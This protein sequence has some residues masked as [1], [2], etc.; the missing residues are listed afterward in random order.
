MNIKEYNLSNNTENDF[1]W[2]FVTVEKFLS[3]IL[4]SKL[5]F[6]R[7][8]CFEDVQEG[9]SLELLLLNHLKDN[10]MTLAPFNQLSQVHSID[11]FPKET[12]GLIDKLKENQKYNFANCWYLSKNN[13]ESVAMWNLYSQPN[14]MALNIKYS[15]FYD[16][17][18]KSKFDSRVNLKTLTFG[19]IKY[20]NFQDPYELNRIKKEIENTAFIKDQSFIHE[21]EFRIVAEIE[22]YENK[23]FSPKKGFSKYKQKEF[24]D[25]N[26]QIY[27]L[28]IS[29]N[30]FLD[31]EFEIVFHPKITSWI[32]KDLIKILN[33]FKIPYKTRDSKLKLN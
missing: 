4:N 14:G 2:K 32:K 15:K 7:I 25:R 17:I 12:D 30:G 6:T 31:Y 24:Y 9:I 8:D 33:K 10:L 27:G 11:M 13:I 18:L 21:N 26:S 5:Y 23:P 1:L 20:V 22:K 3:I 16:K 29:L 19:R 28:D